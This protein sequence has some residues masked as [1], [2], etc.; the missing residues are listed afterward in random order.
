MTIDVREVT[1]FRV[2]KD[3]V[4]EFETSSHRKNYIEHVL[5]KATTADGLVGWGEA[6]SPSDPFYCYENTDSC[7][8]VLSKYLVPTLLTGLFE[9]P[10]EAL[11]ASPVNGNPFAHAASDTLMWDLFS[12][13]QG[14]ALAD[15]IGGTQRDVSAG[16]SLGIEKT[17]DDLLQVVAQH[18][19][20]GY[21]RVK[22]KISRD[23][24]YEPTRAVR[25]AFPDVAVQVDANG[26]F[27]AGD[28]D[29]PLFTDLDRL[30]LLM[31]EQPFASEELLLHA[32]L[33]QRLETAICLDESITSLG[34]LQTALRL[35]A[36]R[37]VNI[38]VSRLGGVGPARDVHNAC[39]D[40]GVPVWCGG[41][42]EFGVGRAANLAVASLP[43]F[44][45]PSDLSGSKKYYETDVVD[46]EISAHDGMVSVPRS[47][48]GLGLEILEDRV[49][50][51]ATDVLVLR[52]TQ[53]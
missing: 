31:I 40:A 13:Q 23:W 51:N 38:K 46:P 12:Q 6:A 20:D 25:E 43:G 37:I 32:A 50:A 41:M 35:E 19:D 3:L 36:A 5:V 10:G 18:V 9:T 30:G 27:D 42:H 39:L 44:T 16:V 24:A 1:L 8:Q 4:R 14:L 7:W 48:S 34:V 21:K 45:Y 33:Q 17:I 28:V 26:I 52:T 15:A 53:F 22:L 49:R 47:R 29:N 2:R 11:L